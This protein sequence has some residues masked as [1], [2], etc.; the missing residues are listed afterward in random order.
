[1][2]DEG[3]TSTGIEPLEYIL[4]THPLPFVKSHLSNISSRINNIRLRRKAYP[5]LL[6]ADFQ[7]LR[8]NIGCGSG[9]GGSSESRDGCKKVG[10]EHCGEEEYKSLCIEYLI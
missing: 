2:I 9:K 6:Y 10:N 4:S 7:L 5:A 8:T 1:M 3:V